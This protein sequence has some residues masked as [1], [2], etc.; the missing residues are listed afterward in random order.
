MP[1]IIAS[2]LLRQAFLADAATSAAS[3]ALMMLAA[4]PLGGLLGL[5]DLLLRLAGAVLLPYAALL[6]WLGLR[7]R[8]QRPAA[9]AVVAGNALWAADSVLLLVGGWVEPT[10]AGYAFVVAQALVVV[11]YALLQYA[12]LRRSAAAVA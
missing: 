5:P 6:A 4:G 3:G 2:P 11:M 10:P 1:T 12:G 9:W 7:E 8:L